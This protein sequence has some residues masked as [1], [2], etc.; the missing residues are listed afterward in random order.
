MDI[1]PEDIYQHIFS[2]LLG[3]TVH[4]HKRTR[5]EWTNSGINRLQLVNKRFKHNF[6]EYLKT[7][8]LDLTLWSS[9][10][11][12]LQLLKVLK[13]YDVQNL[14]RFHWTSGMHRYSKFFNNIVKELHGLNFK[15]LRELQLY[16]GNFDFKIL[17]E[18]EGLTD[19]TLRGRRNL[20]KKKIKKLKTFLSF[21]KHTVERLSILH[22]YDVIPKDFSWPNLKHLH[23]QNHKNWPPTTSKVIESNTLEFLSIGNDH[24][25][26]NMVI[27]CPNL[28]DMLISNIGSD[29]QIKSEDRSPSKPYGYND[30]DLTSTCHPSELRKIG[31]K[32]VEVSSNCDIGY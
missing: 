14:Y 17:R 13:K 7:K 18:C 1:I 4:F 3:D 6:E 32:V 2:F 30:E 26:C 23:I 16:C 20:Y 10:E 31:I 25:T 9:N 22:C 29:H 8:P 24:S 15:K 11:W 27:K 19:I 12:N 28:K 21:H 5:R